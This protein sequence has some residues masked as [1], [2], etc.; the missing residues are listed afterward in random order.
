M[1]IAEHTIAS[2][3]SVCNHDQNPMR[4]ANIRRMTSGVKSNA[5]WYAVPEVNVS[6]SDI[7]KWTGTYH[8]SEHN[9]SGSQL[10]IHR[11]L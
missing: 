5:D 6:T 9:R 7:T 1:Y 2:V 8:E 3:R 4:A 10:S 11:T